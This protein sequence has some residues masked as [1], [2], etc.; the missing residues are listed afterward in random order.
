MH[1]LQR[2]LCEPLGSM[3]TKCYSGGTRL[4]TFL[5]SSVFSRNAEQGRRDNRANQFL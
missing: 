5:M 1:A 4:W 3:S 2:Q